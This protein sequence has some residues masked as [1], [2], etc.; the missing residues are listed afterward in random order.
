MRRLS[1]EDL[2]IFYSPNRQ[3]QTPKTLHTE[4]PSC[5]FLVVIHIVARKIKNNVRKVKKEVQSFY[6]DKVSDK[7]R[8]REKKVFESCYICAKFVSYCSYSLSYMYVCR[9]SS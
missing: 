4:L 3:F 6:V 8:K 1:S 7:A 5:L 9:F 2:Y